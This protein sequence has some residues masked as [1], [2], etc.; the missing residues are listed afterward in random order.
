[1]TAVRADRGRPWYERNLAAPGLRHCGCLE[2]VLV[3]EWTAGEDPGPASVTAINRLA[4]LPLLVKRKLAAGLD[5]I[6]VGAGGVPD[7]DDLAALRGVPLP[8]GRA[9]CMPAPVPTATA[10]SSSGRGRR[11]T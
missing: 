9:T 5:A 3:R 1:M 10:R 7:L 2:D 8:S 6:H 11:R 4:E